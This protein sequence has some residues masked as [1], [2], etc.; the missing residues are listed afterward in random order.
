MCSF[1]LYGSRIVYPIINRLVPSPSRFETRRYPALSI[2]SNRQQETVSMPN[3]FPGFS[4][5]RPYE[6]RERE[7]EEREN[8]GT[9][10]FQC[11]KI[12]LNNNTGLFFLE[13]NW[14]TNT[15]RFFKKI[16][17]PDEFKC[18][19]FS[20]TFVWLCLF[21]KVCREGHIDQIVWLYLFRA[22]SPLEFQYLS[23]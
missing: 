8:L 3:S 7:R 2:R 19:P 6:A 10:L 22:C 15:F 9:R 18:H 23:N 16:K 13:F 11:L 17:Q 1:W 5:T 12:A 21:L 4:P 20:M 14:C